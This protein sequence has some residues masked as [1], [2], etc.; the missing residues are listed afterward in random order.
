[1]A[2]GKENRILFDSTKHC[3]TGSLESSSHSA[4]LDHLTNDI[5]LWPFFLLHGTAIP[6]AYYKRGSSGLTQGRPPPQTT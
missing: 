2:L 3:L 4:H 5:A 1:V 6:Q